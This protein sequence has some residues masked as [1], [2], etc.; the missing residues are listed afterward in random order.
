M[1]FIIRPK[2]RKERKEPSQFEKNLRNVGEALT[3]GLQI[4]NQVYG[5]DTAMQQSALNERKLAQL[6]TDQLNQAET[7]RAIAQGFETP[8][9]LM[10]KVQQ[11]ASVSTTPQE[12]YKLHEVALSIPEEGPAQT[13]KVWLQTPEDRKMLADAANRADTYKQQLAL[14]EAKTAQQIKVQEAKEEKALVAKQEK[15]DKDIRERLVPEVGVALTKTDAKDLK[16]AAAAKEEFDS[17]LQEMVDLRNSKGFE[18]LERDIVARGNQLSTQ[19]LLKYK[20]LT[21][22]GVLSKA[23]EDLLNR[24]IPQDIFELSPSR[25][26][27]ADPIM[28]KL[29]ALQRR[30]NDDYSFKVQARLDRDATATWRGKELDREQQIAEQD[31]GGDLGVDQVIN[32]VNEELKRRQAGSVVGR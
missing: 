21:K 26:F 5:I 13:Q 28:A 17:M 20:D 24:I 15:Q 32:A 16:A 3:T 11:G 25:V 10:S 12:G 7:K 4:A 29:T 9:S 27:G 31:S 8:S 19:L 6:D 2:E 22:L 23:D 14:Q 1:A 30:V 18:V